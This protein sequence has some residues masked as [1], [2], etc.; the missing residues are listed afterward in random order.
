MQIS[1]LDNGE[2][3]SPDAQISDLGTIRVSLVWTSCLTLPRGKKR[4]YVTPQEP[5]F[6]HERAAKK[7]HASAVGLGEVVSRQRKLKRTRNIKLVDAGLAPMVFIFR[8]A[9]RGKLG[10]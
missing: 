3:A 4:T 6:I 10:K 9:P 1:G 5:G 8:Y 7:G 2:L